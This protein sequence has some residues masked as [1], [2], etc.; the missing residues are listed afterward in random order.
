VPDPG[1]HLALNAQKEISHVV[2][3]GEALD[4]QRVDHGAARRACRP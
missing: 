3:D 4:Q 1:V 2:V